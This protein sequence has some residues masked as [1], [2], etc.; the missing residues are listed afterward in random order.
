MKIFLVQPPIEDFYTTPIRLFPLGLFYLGSYLKSFNHEVLILDSLQPFRKRKIPFPEE[1]LYLKEYYSGDQE[2]LLFK[3][4]WHYGMDI[5]E[6]VIQAQE[7]RPDLIGISSNFTAYF[8]SVK[9]LACALKKVFPNTPLV[10]GGAHATVCFS[11]ILKQLPEVDYIVTGEGERPLAAL[12]EC[13]Q[14]GKDFSNI[15]GL[16]YRY[17]G[18]IRV[19]PVK[20]VFNWESINLDYNLLL[21]SYKYMVGRKKAVSMISSRGC[22]FPCSFC[23]VSNVFGKKIRYRNSTDLVQEMVILR[24]RWGIELF[25]FEDDN[26]SLDRDWFADFLCKIQNCPELKGIELTAMNGLCFHTLDRKIINLM[27]RAGF[28]RLNLSLV[29]DDQDL[30]SS[31]QRLWR[32][33]YLEEI[34]GYASAEGFMVSVYIIVGLPGQTSK[35]LMETIDY[36]MKMKVLVGP[37][38]FYP[39]PGTSVTRDCQDRGLLEGKTWSHYRSSAFSVETP[40]LSRKELFNI[41]N[42]CR[43]KSLAVL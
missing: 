38:V 10:L 2:N 41:V 26:I 37:S 15:E 9:E 31:V 14:K 39:V 20:K 40:Q 34:V 21:N 3:N 6:I 4:Y 18:L 25:N 17:K 30:L 29:S 43:K 13:L 28:I 8:S 7:Y 1:F 24:Q 42:Y 23:G 27:R 11:E 36:L 5:R 12:T 22:P 33:E 35:K 19:V 16:A 32:K